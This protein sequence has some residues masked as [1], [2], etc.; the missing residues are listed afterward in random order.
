MKAMKF[1]YLSVLCVATIM[2]ASC[3][4][5]DDEFKYNSVVP[6]GFDIVLVD[7]EGNNI[8]TDDNINSA[9]NDFYIVYDGDTFRLDYEVYNPKM[10]FKGVKLPDGGYLLR[11]G[12]FWGDFENESFLICYGKDRQ[13]EISFTSRN[14]DI[15]TAEGKPFECIVTVNGEVY[16]EIFGREI[17]LRLNPNK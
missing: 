15:T 8:L 9:R 6:Y 14:Y 2:T 12:G 4:N 13:D 3:S 17:T 10:T 1:L 5:D 7:D 16:P 11:F